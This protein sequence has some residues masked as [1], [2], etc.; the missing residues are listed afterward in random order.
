MTALSANCLIA[1]TGSSV[2]SRVVTN[3]ELSGIVETSDEW[4]KNRT[5]ISQ[6]RVVLDGETTSTLAVEASRKAIENARVDPGDLEL[7]IVATTSPDYSIP[8]TA[9]LIQ[10]ELGFSGGPAFDISAAC[11]G[12]VYAIAVASQL[13]DAD[14]YRTALVVGADCLS[15]VMDW[16]DR[17]TCILFGDGAGAVVLK[18]SEV[19]EGGGFLATYLGADGSGAEM[20]FASQK[21]SDESPF[22]AAPKPSFFPDTSGFLR[23]NGRETFKFA[24]RVIVDAVDRVLQS[25]GVGIDEIDHFIPHQANSRIVDSSAEALHLESDKIVSNIE[26]LGNT[27]AASI[28]IVLDQMRSDGRLKDGQLILMVGFGGGLTWGASLYRW[29]EVSDKVTM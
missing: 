21:Y 22:G 26:L 14:L 24:V 3:E 2:P 12:F 7:T 27:S 15:R 18:K 9:C 17:S 8:S 16:S 19:S 13:I 6:R 23:M 5:G 28:P 25:A 20:L 4:I 10:R 29:K 11:T 1:G